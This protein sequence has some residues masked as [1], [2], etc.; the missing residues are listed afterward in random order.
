MIIKW[1][2]EGEKKI[3]VTMC[4]WKQKTGNEQNLGTKQHFV[5]KSCSTR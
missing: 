4:E 2:K 3:K 1:R 5:L